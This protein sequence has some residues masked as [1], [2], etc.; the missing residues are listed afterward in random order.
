MLLDWIGFLPIMQCI[1]SRHVLMHYHAQF[2]L[3]LFLERFAMFM[4]S[5]SSLFSFSFLS[6]APKKSFPSWNPISRHRYA[7]SSSSIPPPP[8]FYVT[9][10][11]NKKSIRRS[12]VQ[13][14]VKQPHVET[15][16]ATPS[17]RPSSSSAHFPPLGLMSLSLT[18]WISFSIWVLILVVVSTI[19]L[20]RCT[21]WTPE[22]VILLA[23][24]L[25]LLVSH[26]HLHLSLL[27]SLLL[28]E[29]MMM[30]L[31]VLV[32]LMMMRWRLLSDTLFVTHDK[33]WSS[34]VYENNHYVRG[35]ASIGYTR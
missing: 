35:R 3:S 34:F 6:I 18:S 10:A 9:G 19:C 28:V 30:M 33:R 5:F 17:L 13:L 32:L 16:N 15:T 14:A 23:F 26:P 21:R 22:L 12:A 24:S 4:F 2:F 7:S 25:A 11:I 31:M 20:M 8:L 27:R 29:M 1:F